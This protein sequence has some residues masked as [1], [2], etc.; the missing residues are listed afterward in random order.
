MNKETFHRIANEARTE[1]L[2]E[3]G[4]KKEDHNKVC[5]WLGW[6]EYEPQ[7]REV[8]QWCVELGDGR[9]DATSI[10]RICIPTHSKEL[11][12]KQEIKRRIHRWGIV[13]PQ[14]YKAD[15]H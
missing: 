6:T 12:A 9:Q 11:E 2:L 14:N 13:P 3:M 8:I 4:Y 7:D 15:T 1:A 5:A 10:L